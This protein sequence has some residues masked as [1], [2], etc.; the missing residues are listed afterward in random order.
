MA[1]KVIGIISLKGGVG[2]TTTVSAL[3][4]VLANDFKKKVLLIDANFS[5]PNLALHFGMVDPEKTLHHVLNEDAEIYEAIH[6]VE[7]GFHIIPGSLL[8][9]KT[10]VLKLKDK[11]QKLKR[12]YDI[13]LID[14]SPSL[15]DEILATMMASDE[16]IVITTPDYPTLSTTLRA[17]IVAKRNRT[18]IIGIVLNKVRNKH[19]ELSLE[20]IEKATDIK[21]LAVL[22]DD[23]NILES[24]AKTVPSIIH[25]PHANSSVEYKKLAAALIGEKYNDKR[26]RTKMKSILFGKQKKTRQD[27]NRDKFRRDR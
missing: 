26:F 2:K 8:Y 11:I 14:S 13:I 4:A 9:D 3:G 6:E 16:L 7:H 27:M 10:R 15:N 12:V 20:E 5:A 24:L 22:P 21:V 25:K 17:A 19:F 18:P 1:G 23:T